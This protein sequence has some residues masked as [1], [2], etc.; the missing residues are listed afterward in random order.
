MTSLGI[1]FF[2]LHCTY[3]ITRLLEYPF[4]DIKSFHHYHHHPPQ[5]DPCSCLR[6]KPSI[7]FASLMMVMGKKNPG[8][9]MGNS[10][11]PFYINRIFPV[12]QY[13]K[14]VQNGWKGLF[15]KKGQ[16]SNQNRK[17]GN[18]DSTCIDAD[19]KFRG[20]VKEKVAFT[21]DPSVETE[22]N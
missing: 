20:G 22:P 15:T 17:I 12:H 7:D 13:H 5:S 10:V 9:Y 3:M 14:T 21:F 2:F 1:V 19:F 18:I 11:Y 4:F 6:T 8:L 16:V